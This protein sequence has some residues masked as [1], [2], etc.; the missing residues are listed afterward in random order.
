VAAKSL[1]V[2]GA[3][4]ILLGGVPGLWRSVVDPVPQIAFSEGE[5]ESIQSDRK[6]RY[7]KFK[8]P[9]VVREPGD[10]GVRVICGGA[11]ANVPPEPVPSF[12]PDRDAQR[13]VVF[14]EL[15]VPQQQQF[16]RAVLVVFPIREEFGRRLRGKP[17]LKVPIPYLRRA[18]G[19]PDT[20]FQSRK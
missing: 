3:L 15:P 1:A 4:V 12:V 7:D 9:L 16:S 20:S 2:L 5:V 8:V 13:L 18:L 19:K 14:F 6:G 10:W 11:L 17:Q